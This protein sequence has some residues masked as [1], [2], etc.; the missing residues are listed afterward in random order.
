MPNLVELVRQRLYYDSEYILYVA[1][2]SVPEPVVPEG[3][4][5]ELRPFN[6]LGAASREGLKRAMG[7][8]SYFYM[9]ARYQRHDPWVLLFTKNGQLANYCWI[10]DVSAHVGHY[11]LL[12]P[13]CRVVGPGATVPEFRRLGLHIQMFR[14]Y[15]H[16]FYLSARPLVGFVVTSNQAGMRAIEKAGY[17][18]AYRFT[19]HV[20][21]GRRRMEIVER[22]TSG[23]PG[24]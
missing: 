17:S 1:T 16:H 9:S 21:F 13:D 10:S 8:R 22:F 20:R 11:P 19:T 7:A 6:R 24:V 2:S 18:R 15:A 4:D 12:F 14:T 5:L 3:F 23:A